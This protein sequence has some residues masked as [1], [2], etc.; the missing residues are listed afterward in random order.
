VLAPAPGLHD[1]SEQPPH[2]PVEPRPHRLGASLRR[3]DDGR[4]AVGGHGRHGHARHRRPHVR[5][6]YAGPRRQRA[7]QPRRVPALRAPTSGA[8]SSARAPTDSP[9]AGGS[10]T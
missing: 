1:G 3:A 2:L 10:T 8:S 9:A 5:P 4:R 6:R 7:E